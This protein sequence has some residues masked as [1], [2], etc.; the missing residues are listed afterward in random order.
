MKLLFYSGI[1][2][3]S[4]WKY[5]RSVGI[6]NQVFWAGPDSYTSSIRSWII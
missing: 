3:T 2:S 1:V 6:R 5:K 4:D